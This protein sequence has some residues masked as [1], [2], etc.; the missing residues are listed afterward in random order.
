MMWISVI[1]AVDGGATGRVLAILL[2]LR[3]G[4]K[5]PAAFFADIR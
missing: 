1:I 2:C 3:L 5:P 4:R